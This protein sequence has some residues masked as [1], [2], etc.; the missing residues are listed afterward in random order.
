MA[1]DLGL[2]WLSIAVGIPGEGEP[3]RFSVM[4]ALP[5]FGAGLFGV[6]LSGVGRPNPRELI[7]ADRR[8]QHLGEPRA[9]GSGGQRDPERTD[10]V[11]EEV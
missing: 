4:L 8:L 5:G 1:L 3:M 9:P 10:D 7:V 2:G 6:A 11:D